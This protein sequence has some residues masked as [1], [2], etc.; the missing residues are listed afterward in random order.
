MQIGNELIEDLKIAISSIKKSRKNT[1]IKTK[2]AKS[3]KKGNKDFLK[4]LKEKLVWVKSNKE[5]AIDEKIAAMEKSRL[6]SLA[7]ENAMKEKTL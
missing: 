4:A 6:S 1:D 5:E 2:L 3:M 7:A